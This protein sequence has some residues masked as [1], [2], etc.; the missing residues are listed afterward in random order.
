MLRL[1]SFFVVLLSVG[2]SQKEFVVFNVDSLLFQ[3]TGSTIFINPI[4][5]TMKEIHL[6]LST[7]RGKEVVL[8]GRISEISEHLTYMVISDDNARML[9]VLTGIQ[10]SVLKR[11]RDQ[12]SIVRVLGTIESG[13]KGLPFIMARALNINFNNEKA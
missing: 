7:M 1:V 8:K 5:P 12:S 9:V 13:Q 11:H 10:D 3:E 6:D 4:E 2:C